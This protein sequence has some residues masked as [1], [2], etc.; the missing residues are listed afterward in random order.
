MLPWCAAL[1]VA[2][3]ALLLAALTSP[4][5][6]LAGAQHATGAEPV[7]TARVRWVA[8]TTPPA[9]DADEALPAE[10]AAAPVE[11]ATA[12]SAPQV[13]ASAAP[14]TAVAASVGGEAGEASAEGYLPRPLL[15]IAPQPLHPVVV[16]PPPTPSNASRLIGRYVGVL[17]LY[18]D[19]QGIVRSIEA[20]QPAL[21]E[22]MERAAREAFQGARFTPGQ[23][24]GRAVK[25]RIRVEV[26][27]DDG[28]APAAAAASAAS[29]TS[30]GEPAASDT[31]P[32]RLRR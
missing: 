31:Q 17:A 19:E 11:E 26:A 13:A 4:S 28:P 30:Q 10:T 7:I 18:I 1:A 32:G 22:A 29:A 16:A 14:P 20:E 8:P 23:V 25:S 24:D 9:A 27:F 5:P 15:T 2:G 12:A 3:H 21:P 6:R